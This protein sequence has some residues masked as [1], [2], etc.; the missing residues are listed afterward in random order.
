MS[1]FNAEILKHFYWSTN[2]MFVYFSG[3]Y[4]CFFFFF[5]FDTGGKI[6]NS[7]DAMAVSGITRA[8]FIVSNIVANLD[9]ADVE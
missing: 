2:D 8:F 4:S 3:S 1:V 6:C 7:C 9:I 5:V